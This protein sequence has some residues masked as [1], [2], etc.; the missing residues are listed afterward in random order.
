MTAE[1]KT[2]FRNCCA[3]QQQFFQRKFSATAQG[4]IISRQRAR[5]T[6]GQRTSQTQFRI[7]L[8]VPHKH[9]GCCG[10]GC[11]LPAIDGDKPAVGQPDQNETASADAGVR[12]VHNAEGQSGGHR[13]INGVASILES[14][15]CRIGSQRMD[16]RN[17]ATP[18]V[19][20]L[21]AGLN[22]R[23]ASFATPPS[24]YQTAW[25]QKKS[26]QG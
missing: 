4:V 23:S 14:F 2:V 26:P 19:R 7:C 16:R 21:P 12:S 5:H 15:Y 20:Q 8:P 22:K 6:S 25:N 1:G 17:D 13:G 11:G 3:G 18:A 24:G 10:R 9:V